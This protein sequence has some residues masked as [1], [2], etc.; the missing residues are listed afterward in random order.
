MFKKKDKW[1]NMAFIANSNLRTITKNTTDDDDIKTTLLSRNITVNGRRTSVRL[2]P[3]MWNA[4]FDI[5]KRENC[6]I[7]DICTLISIRK[8]PKTSLTAGIRVFL[9]LYFR[10][11]ANEEGHAR[12]GHGDIKF[13]K[14]RAG[15]TDAAMRKSAMKSEHN[16]V[17]M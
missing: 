15:L 2:E 3:E 1:G 11:A 6:S 4:L 10:A 13:M 14:D 12:A 7:H 9:M 17:R 16:S 5:A 8:N